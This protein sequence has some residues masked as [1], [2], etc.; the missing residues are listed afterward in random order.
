[1]GKQDSY[2]FQKNGV[3]Q[4][5]VALN[6]EYPVDAVYSLTT[7][8]PVGNA[9]LSREG[10]LT[11]TPPRGVTGIVTMRYRVDKPGVTPSTNILVAV[12]IVP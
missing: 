8:P 7:A 2:T 3:L 6:D 4:A 11:F 1:M 9:T 12:H 10:H 5:N